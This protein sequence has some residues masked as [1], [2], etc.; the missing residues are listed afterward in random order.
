VTCIFGDNQSCIKLSE[1]HVFHDKSK[2]VKIK[3]Q[4]IRDMVQKGVVQLKY[5][6]TDDQI[7]DVLSLDQASVKGKVSVLQGKAWRG[8]KGLP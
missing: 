8:P 2:H 6:G 7:A 3:Y 1:N 4:Y 5:I